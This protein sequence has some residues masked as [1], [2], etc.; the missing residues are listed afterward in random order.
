MVELAEPFPPGTPLDVIISLE[1]KP[2]CTEAKVVWSH[3]SDDKPYSP[4]DHGLKF[5][6]I[7]P[8]DKLQLKH[9]IAEALRR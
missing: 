5:T 7:K 8:W 9:F 1:G 3:N 4:Y 6:S 2:I